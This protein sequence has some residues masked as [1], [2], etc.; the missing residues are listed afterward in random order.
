MLS[1]AQICK[2]STIL[3]NFHS[4]RKKGNQTNDHIFFIYVFSSNCVLFIFVFENF[5]N[6]FSWD[7]P[8]GL[9]WSVKYLNFRGEI[10]E[11]RILFRLIQET[12]NKESKKPGFTVSIKLRTKFVCSHCLRGIFVLITRNIFLIILLMNM[13]KSVIL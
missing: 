2:K 10:C 5:Q 13:I 11:I 9:F 7:P 3:G 4:G 6:S 8:F 12:H 1:S